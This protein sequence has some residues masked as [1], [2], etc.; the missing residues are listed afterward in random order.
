MPNGPRVIR[1]LFCFRGTTYNTNKQNITNIMKSIGHWGFE[2][3]ILIH[4][5]I[6]SNF[7]GV[8]LLPFIFMMVLYLITNIGDKWIFSKVYRNFRAGS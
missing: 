3:N 4:S 6:W 5:V 1:S 2:N 7:T 8:T